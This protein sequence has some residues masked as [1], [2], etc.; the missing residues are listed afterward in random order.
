MGEVGDKLSSTSIDDVS[1]KMSQSQNADS[2]LLRVLL[3]K[4][5][6]SK[7]QGSADAAN[8]DQPSNQEANQDVDR[9]EEIR[10]VKPHSDIATLC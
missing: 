5:L 4:F 10:K 9:L 8:D 2:N 6:N 7:E 1:T 3:S